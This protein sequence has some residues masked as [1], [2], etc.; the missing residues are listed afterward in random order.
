MKK[1]FF[2]LTALTS[3]L[4][5]E[6]QIV[7]IPNANFKAKLLSA[8]STN[9]IAKNLTGS[10]FKIDSNNDN[11]IQV[12]EATQVS[13]LSVP[14]ASITDLTGIS[15][16]TG[17]TQLYVD[18]NQL[19]SLDATAL[20]NLVTLSC[21]QNQINNLNVSALAN[22]KYLYCYENSL[23]TLNVSGLTALE[24]LYCNE[25][26]L[27]TIDVSTL[28]NLN[29]FYCD[30]NQLTS[31]FMKNAKN[32][33]FTFSGNPYVTYICADDSQI[34]AIESQIVLNGYTNCHVNSYC[35][36]AP[37]GIN[38]KIQGT[39]KLDATGNGCDATDLAM[40]FTKF[41]LTSGT[42]TGNVF[43]NQNGFYT[44]NVT[45]G[46]HTIT[47]VLENPTYFTVSPT[48]ANVTFPTT[49][50]PFVQDFCLTANGVHKDLE[51]IIMPIGPARPGFDVVY[52]ITYKN[53]GNQT[54]NGSINFNYND[55]I[56]DFVSANPAV[57]SQS[58]NNLNWDYTNLVPF[59][60][61]T[62][63][64]TL[65]LNSPT[66]TPAVNAGAVL[67]PKATATIAGD[68]TPLDNVFT[69]SQTV[70]NSLDPNDKTCLEGSQLDP[71]K[72]GEYVHYMIRFENTGTFPAQNIVVKDLI[73][74]T[75][76]DI[77]SLRPVAAS[78][79]FET[80]ISNT[81]KVEFIFED[82]N[83]D[84]NDAQNDGF[85]TFKIKTKNNLQLG[86]AF[87]NKA[88]IY[89]DY[90]FPIITNTATTTLATL[91]TNAVSLTN[92]FSI[93][94]NPVSTV[95]NISSKNNTSIKS[96]QIFN[97]VGQLLV[98]QHQATSQVALEH[99]QSGTYIAVIQS[100]N[101]TST[102]KFVKL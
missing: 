30:A 15:S 68:E 3:F 34:A 71:S 41:N 67:T 97:L 28:T 63:F 65:N 76:F 2:L 43:A 87:Q 69:L 13:Y 77:T 92:E 1:L 18:K 100:E 22:L 11:E 50:S 14:N 24:Y 48:S 55:G 4:S 44:V 33:T 6:A 61:R 45:A 64:V 56:L 32:E 72:A 52:K 81:N 102:M 29:F 94:P 82:I 86:D 40:P 88:S 42:N 53:K 47:P 90:N 10:Y 83:L 73:D 37:V 46:T 35:S 39:I 17:L 78:H 25:N 19:T 38:F 36:F 70:V 16:F 101:A 54:L 95:L 8:N 23:T 96:I 60:T 51:I 12:S 91:A 80:K 27:T 79:A 5:L 99:L 75:K 84:F 57:T 98:E 66:E 9:T 58:T 89:F 74:T 31:I 7:T 21:Y 59:E 85:I 26:N 49:T 93:Y 20:T 62:I